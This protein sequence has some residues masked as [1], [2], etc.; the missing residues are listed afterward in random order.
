MRQGFGLL[1][2][3]GGLAVSQG[4]YAV[5]LGDILP[6]SRL[7]QPFSAVIPLTSLSSEE[8]STLEVKLASNATFDE[9]GV[10]RASYLSSLQ[11]TVVTDAAQPYI[12]VHSDQVAHDP[13]LTLL[14]DVRADGARL[15]REFTVLLDPP[16]T[17][18]GKQAAADNASAST[19]S[20]A[21]SKA[22]SGPK[23]IAPPPKKK[24]VAAASAPAT[25]KSAAPAASDSPAATSGPLA[26]GEQYGPV[27]NGETSWSIAYK[28]RP[29]PAHVTMDQMLLAMYET[30]RSSYD[31]GL[32]GLMRG[33]MLT[34]PTLDKIQ[35]VDP[36][37]AKRRVDEL[38]G[39]ASSEPA[40]PAPSKPPV[41]TAAAP[42]YSPPPTMPA[43][44]PEPAAAP[45]A[46]VESP[47]PAPEE[48]AAPAAGK[49]A[50]A[51]EPSVAGSEIAEANTD[52]AATSAED[53]SPKSEP[54][55]P[56]PKPK[57]KPVPVKHAPE[58]SWTDMLGP[59]GIPAVIALLVAGIGFAAYRAWKKAMSEDHTD[60]TPESYSPPEQDLRNPPSVEPFAASVPA[61]P[62]QPETVNDFVQPEP[63]DEFDPVDLS[64]PA[65]DEPAEHD[66]FEELLRSA[67]VMDQDARIE[68]EP[69]EE[70]LEQT[71]L[72]QS[73]AQHKPLVEDFDQ[74]APVGA[75]TLQI[76]LDNNDPLSEAEFHLAYGL[77]DEAATLLKQGI[78]QHPDR[79]D[80]HMKLAETYFAAGKDM[81]F[82]ETAEWLK[83]RVGPEDWQKVA[84][85]GRQLC[86]TV[87]MFAD[88]GPTES[89]DNAS[90]FDM[91]FGIGDLGLPPEDGVT[92][93]ESDSKI[94]E[95]DF[96]AVPIDF[97]V[98]P[99]ED[100]APEVAAPLSREE[101]DSLTPGDNTLDFS[102]DDFGDEA[103]PAES[104]SQPEA[105]AQTVDFDVVGTD[106]EPASVASEG[107]VEA[108]LQSFDFDLGEF[109]AAGESGTAS[110]A[111]A[112]GS[113]NEVSF[114]DVDFGS[115]DV[116][117]G[118]GEEPAQAPTADFGGE[119]LELNLNDVSF[120]TSAPTRVDAPS[121]DFQSTEAGPL[122]ELDLSQ[123]DLGAGGDE[124]GGDA[125]G[126]GDEV[127]TKLD[128]ARAYADMGDHMMARNLLE[129]AARD[130]QP[131][132]QDEA[133]KLLEQLPQ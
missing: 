99:I 92:K 112:T 4:A 7:N 43:P 46:S 19:S 6:K 105:P 15:L 102:L 101:A 55:A 131:A 78:E 56:K 41:K 109:N 97:D 18:A 75:D 120:D 12:L 88:A 122:E 58:K 73:P 69:S 9:M 39:V 114:D 67:E 82:E 17:E 32:N 54:P 110:G 2:L 87:A 90:E 127:S 14:L 83:D 62:E 50:S 33:S 116:G 5:G 79:A 65:E 132:Q 84:I 91:D 57:P 74:Q 111:G 104:A 80:L 30:N 23:P 3:L 100:A 128:L 53:A 95:V 13:F 48:P 81:E 29:D 85:M 36:A 52:A 66:P 27:Q 121:V 22:A 94:S 124:G 118:A 64:K 11:F 77:Y 31:G 44:K 108:E 40:A 61:E 38:K 96:D 113:S 89:S 93:S 47:I 115:L 35:S 130:G 37:T 63:S 21:P 129:E 25:E 106:A 107:N 59:Y 76:D 34:V 45:S 10:E 72:L 42:S 1:L 60:E 26:A 49:S 126:G 123:F 70:E 24:P 28:L 20:T 51:A 125:F 71:Q 103:K 133:R 86:P 117:P 68:T 119:P 16:A 8:A 98:D